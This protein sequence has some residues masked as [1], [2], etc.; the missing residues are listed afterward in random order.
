MGADLVNSLWHL[1]SSQITGLWSEALQWET[2]L[3]FFNMH[4]TTLSFGDSLSGSGA[5]HVYF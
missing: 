4:L 5:D 3:Q 1:C 2:Q